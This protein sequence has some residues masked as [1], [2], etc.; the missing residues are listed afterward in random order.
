M[1]FR[2]GPQD[3][4]S[5]ER[6]PH[7]RAIV[8]VMDVYLIPLAPERYE[9]YCEPAE[10][11]AD[12]HQESSGWC[13]DRL[14]RFRVRLAHIDLH[15]LAQSEA[16]P[17][18]WPQRI[19]SRALRWVAE[20]V[21]EQRLLWRLRKYSAARA[22]YP[23]DLSESQAKTIM[24]RLLQRDVDRH[25]RWMIFHAI[26]VLFVAIVLG[27]IFL[28]IPG[29]ANI[30]AL[31]FGFRLFGHY[32]SMRGARHGMGE[33]A[34]TYEACEPLSALRQALSLPPEERQRSVDEI[35]SR[36]RLLHLPRFFRQAA[37]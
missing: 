15:Y 37:D 5:L 29:V 19:R 14:E 10:E 34:W 22:F 3:L 26:A 33:V 24:R 32:L 12:G 11:R 21:A 31:Y 13:A 23:V 8:A 28:L 27:P 36:L 20:K 2:L 35:S 16:G 1:A 7:L 17:E 30:P 25:R 18:K 9:L 6:R 4:L